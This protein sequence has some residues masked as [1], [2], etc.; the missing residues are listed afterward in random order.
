MAGTP[1]VL[2][3]VLLTVG[4]PVQGEALPAVTVASSSKKPKV[5]S[6]SSP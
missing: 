5:C 2:A 3:L 1:P 6:G 4:S